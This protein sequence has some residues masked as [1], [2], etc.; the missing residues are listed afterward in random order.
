M[1]KMETNKKEKKEEIIKK[2]NGLKQKQKDSK[3]KRIK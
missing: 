3:R 2:Q 1:Q